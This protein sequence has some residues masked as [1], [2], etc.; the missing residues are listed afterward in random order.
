[1]IMAREVIEGT[2]MVEATMDGGESTVMK[3]EIYIY[4][5]ILIRTESTR[6]QRTLIE[7]P[8]SSVLR[9]C[10]RRP[11]QIEISLCKSDIPE[12]R[13]RRKRYLSADIVTNTW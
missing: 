11:S 1:M 7:F 5:Y 12:N 13:P 8:P 4:I 9:P 6:A 10:V 2:D 3:W